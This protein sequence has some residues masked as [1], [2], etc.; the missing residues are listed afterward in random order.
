MSLLLQNGRPGFAR[1]AAVS[2]AVRV[3]GMGVGFVL[4]AVLARTLGPTEYGHYLYALAWMNVVLLFAKFDLDVSGVRFVSAAAS[5][6]DWRTVR[7]FVRRSTALVL[8]FSTALAAIGG[9]VTLLLRPRLVTSRAETLL[10]SCALLPVTALLAL[11][12]GQHQGL[13]R[14]FW[15]QGPS[16]VIRPMATVAMLVPLLTVGVRLHAWHAVAANLVASVFALALSSYALRRITAPHVADTP[17]RYETR[18]WLRTSSR[19]IVASA[20]QYVIGTQ[21]DVL[22]VGSFRSASEAALYSTAAQLAT[23]VGFGW[24]A[25]GS[26]A[27]PYIAEYY[28]GRRHEHLQALLGRLAWVNALVTFPLLLGVAIA[29]RL[30][31]SV[32]GAPFV[33][34]YAPLVILAASTT[35]AAMV[36]GTAGYA[37]SMTGH[38]RE[39]LWFVGGTAILNLVLTLILTPRYGIVATA[40]STFTA[41]AVR[42]ILLTW[43]VRRRLGL[44]V[45][46]FRAEGLRD[47]V[48]RARGALARVGA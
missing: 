3:G 31:L 42:A 25:I 39:I 35:V 10:L 48:S 33:D 29:G 40:A 13:K 44:D 30:V 16:L 32:F 37:M 47:I 34:A 1:N 38:E 5:S 36:G 12:V 2:L 45:L 9:L 46:D 24:L 41:T 20:A 21:T 18:F 11:Q 27:M 8:L 28:A 17:P 43:F 4:Q 26:V 22:L 15:A 23:L 6:G 14:L 7:G 19:F